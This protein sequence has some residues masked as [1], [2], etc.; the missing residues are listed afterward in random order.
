MS[1]H[2]RPTTNS[3]HPSEIEIKHM[4]SKQLSSYRLLLMQFILPSYLTTNQVPKED[5]AHYLQNSH[6]IKAI[7]RSSTGGLKVPFPVANVV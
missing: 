3:F 4:S 7:S 1:A 6:L 2:F 5:K